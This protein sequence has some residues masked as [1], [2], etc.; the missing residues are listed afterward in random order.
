MAKKSYKKKKW[1]YKK[2]G[3]VTTVAQQVNR[4][5]NQ[6]HLANGTEAQQS[7]V[8]PELITP[9]STPSSS[10]ASS[11]LNVAGA[12]QATELEAKSAGM[13][14]SESTNAAAAVN[15]SVS[16]SEIE[17]ETPPASVTPPPASVTTPPANG[18]VVIGGY[19]SRRKSKRNKK[20][21]SKRK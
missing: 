3:G 19:K 16:R 9:P 5:S 13:E 1:S 11:P 20:C 6:V 8:A 15:Q 10:I 7:E 14:I 4:T 21:K 2:R 17:L 12:T 18:S